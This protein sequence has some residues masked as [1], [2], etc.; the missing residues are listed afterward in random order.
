MIRRLGWSYCL[1]L[2]ALTSSLV[3]GAAWAQ[4]GAAGG[5][6]GAGGFGTGP[7]GFGTNRL[8]LLQIE[9]VQKELKLTPEQIAAL[10]KLRQELRPQRQGG[11]GAPGAPGG[12]R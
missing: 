1:A 8:M 5:R 11:A 6:G 10:E 9:A 3:A 2:I 12:Q 4:Q 7:G